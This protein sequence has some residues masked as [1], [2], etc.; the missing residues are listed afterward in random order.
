MLLCPDFAQFVERDCWDRLALL[1]VQIYFAV[2]FP[3]EANTQFHVARGKENVPQ[4]YPGRHYLL[5]RILT[6]SGDEG[7]GFSYIGNKGGEL[8]LLAVRDLLKEHVVGEECTHVEKIWENMFK[9]C[10]HHLE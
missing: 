7:I 5:V 4:M 3:R 8:G 10:H 6:E 9:H 1:E 2:Y